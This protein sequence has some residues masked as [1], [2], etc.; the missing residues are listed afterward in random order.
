M[1]Q[2]LATDDGVGAILCGCQ[3]VDAFFF[4]TVARRIKL[5]LSFCKNIGGNIDALDLLRASVFEPAHQ[6]AF[7]ATGLQN[8]LWLRPHNKVVECVQEPVHKIARKRICAFILV[9]EIAYRNG[10][11]VHRRFQSFWP[12]WWRLWR[13]GEP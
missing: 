1:F 5:A 6:G 4:E 13:A 10:R 7:P 3:I 9:F 11:R 8:R 12:A 2:N